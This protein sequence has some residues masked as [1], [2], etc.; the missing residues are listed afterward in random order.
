[1]LK[2]ERK[3]HVLRQ[4]MRTPSVSVSELSE[5]F[6]LSAVSVRK[7]LA[8]MESEGSIQ[9]IWGGA[10]LSSISVDVSTQSGLNTTPQRIVEKEAIAKTAYACIANGETIFIDGGTP[11]QQQLASILANGNKRRVMICTNALPVALEF[12]HAEDMQLVFIGG[13][14]HHASMCCI[15]GAARQMLEKLS[16]D[17]CFL[18]AQHFSVE[19]G[20]TTNSLQEAEV[21][22][23][24]LQSS[25]ESYFLMDYSSY[26][27][28]ALSLIAPCEPGKRLI[29]DWQIPMELTMRLETA[30]LQ[31]IVARPTEYLV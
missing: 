4:L 23:T 1:M 7:L 8:D 27:N 21:K 9:R 12:R 29:T 6:H 30:G 2:E 3:T 26:G 5:A 22:R 28:D 18:S 20:F 11:I 17:K 25:R 16:F 19:R 14:L 24:L 10:M 15:G 31:V 13:Q